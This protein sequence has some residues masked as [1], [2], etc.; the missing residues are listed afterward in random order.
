MKG[1]EIENK[2]NKVNT[3]DADIL[4]VLFT[5]NGRQRVGGKHITSLIKAFTDSISI[6]PTLIVIKLIP[7]SRI[8][9]RFV[10][11]MC[12]SFTSFSR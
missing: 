10:D 4:A 2:H 8:A 11:S 7:W 9:F 5:Y 1:E 6:A 3:A 12:D